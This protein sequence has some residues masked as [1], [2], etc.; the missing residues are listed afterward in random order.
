MTNIVRPEIAGGISARASK[1]ID[2]CQNASSK[3]E[4]LDI[5]VR[6]TMFSRAIELF[7]DGL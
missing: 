4:Q 7:T 3:G 2:Q 1:V 6:Q 5:Y